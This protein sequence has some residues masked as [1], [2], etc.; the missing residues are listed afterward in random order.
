MVEYEVTINK[1]GAMVKREHTCCNMG[2]TRTTIID[3][4]KPLE[5]LHG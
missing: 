1:K 3:F 5:K 2:G 4:V